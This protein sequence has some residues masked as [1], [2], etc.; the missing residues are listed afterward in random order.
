MR[1]AL[2]GSPK[3]A[4]F[5]ETQAIDDSLGLGTFAEVPA[6]PVAVWA[7]ARG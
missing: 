2:G 5:A 3:W 6:T 1:R 4:R 7:F